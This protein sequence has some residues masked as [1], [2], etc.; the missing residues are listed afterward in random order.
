MKAGRKHWLQHS[1]QVGFSLVELAC[2]LA[3]LAVLVLMVS[4][5]WQGSRETNALAAARADAVETR[6]ALQAFVLQQRRLPCPDLSGNGREGNAS[7]ACPVSGQ[8]GWL[9]H[10]ALGL[11]TR[12][13]ARI[14]YAVYRHAGAGIDLVA[15]LERGG[16]SG[17]YEHD[18]LA[19]ISE[20][21]VAA[22][23]TAPATT[24]VYTT[25][26]DLTLGPADCSQALANPAFI[27][28]FPAADR[29]GDGD[30]FDRIHA[31]Y[32]TT[33]GR[34]FAAPTLPFNHDYDDI[35]LA[36]SPLTLLGWLTAGAR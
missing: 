20:Q 2:A 12:A 29:D 26:D 1:A 10:V 22:A 9:P 8:A 15:P 11:P 17:S 35:V 28:V 31:G 3:V 34:C 25:G 13:P 33:P 27:A 36:E 21:L 32:S 16:G 18:R 14:A 5:A 7:G 24:L 6:A 4:G 23:A 19:A 30:L